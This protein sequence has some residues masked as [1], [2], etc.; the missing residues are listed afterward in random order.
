MQVETIGAIPTSS[1]NMALVYL[2]LRNGYYVDLGFYSEESR[3]HFLEKREI[4]QL[5]NIKFPDTDNLTI[6]ASIPEAVKDKKIVFVSPR[7][8][9]LRTTLESATP[10]IQ[11]DAIL[12]CGTKGF[13]EYQ[14]KFYTPS[15]V[16]E[17]IIPNSRNRLVMVSGPNFAGQIINGIVTATTVAAHK[18]RVAQVV[19]DILDTDNN[20]NGRDFLV[21]IYRGNP[22]DIE[23]VG[24]FKNVVGLVMGFARTLDHYGENTGASILT[25]GLCEASLLCKKMRRSS[26]AVMQLPGIGDYGL[27]MNSMSSRNVEAGYNFGMGQWDLEYLMNP[28][29]TIEGIRT[30]KAVRYLAGKYIKHMPLAAYAYEILYAGKDSQ[31]ATKEF[32]SGKA[33]VIS[34]LA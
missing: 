15:Q 16:I 28:D 14:G 22:Q 32:L 4:K 23:I 33:P 18:R 19:K 25:E 34:P 10:Y 9:D 2:A 30:V 1:M 8:W 17:Q 6:A 29:H 11:S 12:V 20:G 27:L 21:N 13:D 26:R 5:P 3:A 31:Q 7:S 24:A